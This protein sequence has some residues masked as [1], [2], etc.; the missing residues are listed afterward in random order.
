[1]LTRL[2]NIALIFSVLT[3]LSGST[4]CASHCEMQRKAVSNCCSIPQDKS[5]DASCCIAPAGTFA[6]STEKF[7]LPDPHSG[8]IPPLFFEE[9]FIFSFKPTMFSFEHRWFNYK[10]PF[11]TRDLSLLNEVFRI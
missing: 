7:L 6:L 4:I 3:V 11:I 10:T 2:I 8:Y 5:D 1:M 9:T